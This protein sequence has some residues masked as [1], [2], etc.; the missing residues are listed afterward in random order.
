VNP[1]G[2]GVRKESERIEGKAGWWLALSTT[3]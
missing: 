2:L 3:L 1:I